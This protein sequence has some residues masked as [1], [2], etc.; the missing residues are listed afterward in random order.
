MRLNI[1]DKVNPSC[2]VFRL[3]WTYPICIWD[4]KQYEEAK[5]ML[6]PTFGQYARQ[7]NFISYGPTTTPTVRFMLG[8]LSKGN[9]PLEAKWYADSRLWTKASKY[10]RYDFW[11]VFK[12]EKDRTLAMM[13]LG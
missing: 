3:G 6:I 10:P 12:T 7:W 2:H 5:N 1:P 4:K 8:G 9:S 11:I 13:L